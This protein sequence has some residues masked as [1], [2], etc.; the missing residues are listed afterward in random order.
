MNRSLRIL[1]ST[2][3]VA[4]ATT[5]IA[6]CGSEGIQLASSNPDY[7]GAEIFANHCSG[8]HTLSVAGTQGSAYN[9]RTR[10]YKDG[11]NFDQR[12]EN[13]QDVLYA[14]RNGGF[15][16]GP[17]PQDIVTGSSAQRVAEFVAKYSGDKVPHT[18][19]P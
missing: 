19:T 3:A 4:G 13:V 7:K 8:C 2:V 17:M 12:K 1:L 6:S 15:S 9:V 5:A 18:A 10:E 16:S 14:L 11:P